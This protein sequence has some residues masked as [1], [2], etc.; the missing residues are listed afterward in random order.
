VA[1]WDR[2]EDLNN[3][4][5][6]WGVRHW[7]RVAKFVNRPD[8]PWKRTR[9]SPIVDVAIRHYWITAALVGLLSSALVA[10]QG[11]PVVLTRAAVTA[12]W[13]GI[14]LRSQYGPARVPSDQIAAKT[15]TLPT[16]RV[17]LKLRDGRVVPGSIARARYIQAY[18]VKASDVIDV[19]ARPRPPAPA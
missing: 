14:L 13:F 18:R 8:T 3:R 12:C 16:K 1:F 5:D 11:W 6:A 15:A 19:A 2:V 7:P 10:D 4:F 17:W 9:W